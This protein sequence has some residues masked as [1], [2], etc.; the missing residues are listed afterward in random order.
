MENKKLTQL[1]VTYNGLISPVEENT[2]IT[3]TQ[4]MCFASKTE[5][6]NVMIV[7]PE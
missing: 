2:A 3:G 6:D 5:L 7:P 1:I 4:R